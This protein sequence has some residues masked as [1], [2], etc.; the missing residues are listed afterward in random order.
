MAKKQ[1]PNRKT[2]KRTPPKQS[3]PK[4]RVDRV[5]NI[6]EGSKK[7]FIG[8]KL[9]KGGK[10]DPARIFV[11]NPYASVMSNPVA[12]YQVGAAMESPSEAFLAALVRLVQCAVPVATAFRSLGISNAKYQ[13]WRVR[14][15]QDFN[16]GRETAFTRL[17]TIVE[18]AENQGEALAAVDARTNPD[19]SMHVLKFRYG[20]N[21]DPKRSIEHPTHF[22]EENTAGG[23]EM[24][25]AEAAYILSLLQDT[26]KG[27]AEK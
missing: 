24:P 13:Q 25:D 6:L 9:F 1:P 3:K 21:W 12:L 7:R 18:I 16:D 11:T 4:A 8:E 10:V 2:A 17:F 14:A 19:Y 26:K 15:Q 5:I 23:A 27:K 20:R 22:L